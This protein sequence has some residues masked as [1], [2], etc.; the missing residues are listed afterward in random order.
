MPETVQAVIAARLDG[1]PEGPRRLVQ[2]AAV[3]GAEFWPGA[4]V[5]LSGMP[6]GAVR[7]GLAE[8]EFGRVRFYDPRLKQRLYEIAKDFAGCSR[9][10]IPERCQTK[11]R[12]MAA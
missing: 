2:D 6:E 3:V 11:A 1:I 5:A 8:E 7:D 4:L 9:G 12:T 10:P